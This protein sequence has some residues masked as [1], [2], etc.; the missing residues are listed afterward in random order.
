M[1]TAWPSMLDFLV[2]CDYP[3]F[4]PEVWLAPPEVLPNEDYND[5]VFDVAIEEVV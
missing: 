2:T 5:F 4:L 3:P 1:S